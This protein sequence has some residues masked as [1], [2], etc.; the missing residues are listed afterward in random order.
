[1]EEGN[2]N[3]FFFFLGND[4]NVN[5]TVTPDGSPTF[6]HARVKMISNS[7]VVLNTSSWTWFSPQ[8]T[9]PPSNN[10]YGAFSFLYDDNNIII[11]GGKEWNFNTPPFK[12]KIFI[13]I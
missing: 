9:G 12:K 1:M 6:S 5:I 2:H 8:V 10:R 13:L 11:G 7:L 4:F 3:T